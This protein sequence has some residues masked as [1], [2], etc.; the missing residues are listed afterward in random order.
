MSS[1]PNVPQANQGNTVAD[2]SQ[3]GAAKTAS[4][5]QSPPAVLGGQ[6]PSPAM[7]QQGQGGTNMNE[8]LQLM[9]MLNGMKGLN[10]AAQ[11]NQN[12]ASAGNIT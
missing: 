6:Q 9:A 7:G 10:G 12:N 8:N 5:N 2:A 4:L 1:N 3:S 11:Q